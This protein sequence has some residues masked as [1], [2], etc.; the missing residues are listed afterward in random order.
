MLMRALTL[1][2]VVLSGCGPL[3]VPEDAPDA[4]VYL[5]RPDP[6]SPVNPCDEHSTPAACRAS[7]AVDAG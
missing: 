1:V 5:D 7:G 4:G 6:R 2:I 3:D